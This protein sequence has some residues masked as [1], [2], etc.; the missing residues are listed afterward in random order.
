M[1]KLFFLMFIATALINTAARAQSG[2]VTAVYYYGPGANL[3]DSFSYWL[4]D[5]GYFHY[6]LLDGG[7]AESMV[8]FNYEDPSTHNMIPVSIVQPGGGDISGCVYIGFA[9]GEHVTTLL[10]GSGD[11]IGDDAYSPE[12]WDLY[13]SWDD[14]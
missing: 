12:G 7:S 4:T 13:F 10:H 1:K 3:H 2:T 6:S 14:N 9:D 8:S 5:D 11:T